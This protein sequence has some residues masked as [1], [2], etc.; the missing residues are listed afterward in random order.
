[1]ASLLLFS[2]VYYVRGGAATS[3]RM[4]KSTD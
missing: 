2:A 4:M 3:M 1:G